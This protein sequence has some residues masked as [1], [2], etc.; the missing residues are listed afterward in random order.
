MRH[1]EPTNASQQ[2]F[3]DQ[4]VKQKLVYMK[5]TGFKARWS[6]VIPKGTVTNMYSRYLRISIIN[7][8]KNRPCMMHCLFI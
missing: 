8:T 6:A 2:E 1:K 5:Y 7:P 3:L 4:R